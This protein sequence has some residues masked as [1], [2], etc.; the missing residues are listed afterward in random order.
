MR[1]TLTLILLVGCTE[2]IPVDEYSNAIWQARCDW[3]VRCGALAAEDCANQLFAPGGIN[4]AAVKA[5][6]ATY[7][8]EAAAECLARYA[9]LP[10][11]VTEEYPDLSVCGEVYRGLKELGEPCTLGIECADGDCFYPDGGC[12]YACCAG[13]VGG[14]CDR[15]PPVA[16]DAQLGESCNPVDNVWC[17]P[18]LY[19]TT[20]VSTEDGICAPL[21]KHG[22]PCDGY[23]AELGDNCD[24]T[25][26]LCE[27]AS[28]RGEPCMD[29]SDCTERY[30]CGMDNRCGDG[31]FK[32]LPDG[33]TCQSVFDCQ[34]S[35]CENSVC[36]P[37][38]VCY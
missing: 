16:P 18:G 7:D 2:S 29:D 1:L 11:D 10:C 6:L 3:Y 9:E 33:S 5:G 25:T 27:D 26:R 34:S 12:E 17:G 15:E 32:L 23:C 4:A 37:F 35:L 36:V 28:V 22:E 14:T 20:H 31:W 13:E 30:A 38:P 24:S 19:C 21:P 8:A